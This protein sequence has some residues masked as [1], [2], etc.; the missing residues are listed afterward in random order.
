MFHEQQQISTWA[1]K[2]YEV[3]EKS[4]KPKVSKIDYLPLLTWVKE[5]KNE[6]FDRCFSLGRYPGVPVWC[7]T[8]CPLELM[9]HDFQSTRNVLFSDEIWLPGEK[10]LLS[11][12]K[13]GTNLQISFLNLYMFQVNNFPDKYEMIFGGDFKL[14]KKRRLQFNLDLFL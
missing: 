11:S 8:R 12:T 14:R 1:E 7:W 4:I 6:Q 9:V 2:N 10:Y 5:M 13:T 3:I